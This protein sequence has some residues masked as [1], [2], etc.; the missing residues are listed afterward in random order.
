MHLRQKEQ[1]AVLRMLQRFLAAV[2]DVADRG[3]LARLK[4]GLEIKL[5]KEHP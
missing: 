5:G 2:D 1:E 3:V 4:I